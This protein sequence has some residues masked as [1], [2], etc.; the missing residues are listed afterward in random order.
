MFLTRWTA[1]TKLLLYVRITSPVFLCVHEVIRDRERAAEPQ[2][3]L[4]FSFTTLLE[5]EKN[6]YDN[7]K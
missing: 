3:D 4:S 2:H 1:I 7:R 6:E 5:D